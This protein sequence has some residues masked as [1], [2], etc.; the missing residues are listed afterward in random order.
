ME[1]Q[2]VVL[3]AVLWAVAG[4]LIVSVILPPLLHLAGLTRYRIEIEDRPVDLEPAGDDPFYDDLVRQLAE[5]G[6]RPLGA[7]EER[8][9]FFA[10][11]YLW[12]CRQR[13]FASKEHQAFAVLYRFIAG[14]PIR[15][16]YA[17]CFADEALL[18]TGNHSEEAKELS[19]DHVR[20][21]K[22]TNNMAELL[23]RH[24]QAVAKFATGRQYAVP[25]DVCVLAGCVE[26][27][28]RRSIARDKQLP[29]LFLGLPFMLGGIF[30]FIMTMS[31]G[32][33]STAVPIAVIGEGCLFWVVH[34]PALLGTIKRDRLAEVKKAGNTSQTPG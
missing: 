27:H 17:S 24:R 1:Q 7:F 21:G 29:L 16:A 14:E 28:S 2:D 15:M 26:K 3:L 22:L 20:W 25:D 34:V 4:L 12:V 6:F 5:L 9:N 30:P 8:V 33:A 11:H 10:L 13:V 19:A 23:E 32:L 18:W 31:F